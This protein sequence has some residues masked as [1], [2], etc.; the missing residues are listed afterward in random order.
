MAL[1]ALDGPD[2]AT[3][4]IEREGMVTTTKTS[5]AV[6]VHPLVK[7]ERCERLAPFPVSPLRH[8]GTSARYGFVVR[9]ARGSN[10]MA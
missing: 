5:G 6:R 9:V 1:E 2:A 10:W 3:A 4:V 7:A 8:P